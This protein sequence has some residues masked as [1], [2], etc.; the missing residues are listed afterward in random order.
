V[1]VV[2]A[3][4]QVNVYVTPTNIVITAGAGSPPSITNGTVILEWLSQA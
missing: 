4:N 1:D 3:P 2:S